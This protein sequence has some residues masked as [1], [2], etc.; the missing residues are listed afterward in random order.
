[1]V[2]NSNDSS[3]LKSILADL[4]ASFAAKNTVEPKNS[5]GSPIALLECTAAGLAL[6]L[7]KRTRKSI[8]HVVEGWDL[9]VPGPRVNIVPGFNQSIS[10]LP[11]NLLDHRQPKPLW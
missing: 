3:A 11:H 9:H 8:G 5:G 2:L 10:C 1:M 7:S 6:S 4:I